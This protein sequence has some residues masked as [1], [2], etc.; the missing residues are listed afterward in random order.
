MTAPL[1]GTKIVE[2]GHMIAVPTATHLMAGY[3]ADVIKV[4]DLHGGD[5]VRVYA[6]QKNGMG[7][8]FI[9]ANSGKRSIALDLKTDAAKDVLWRLIDWADI[10]IEGFRP[11]VTARL[12]FGHEAVQKRRPDIIYCT[13][14]GFGSDGPYGGRPAFDP[15]IQALTGWAGMQQEGGEPRLVKG[16]VADKVSAYVN[17][18]AMMAAL[19]KKASTGEG[20]H[21]ETTML[22]A[23]IGFN[24]PDMMMDCTLLDDDVVRSDNVMKHYQ[25]YQCADGWISVAA[26]TDAQVKATCE[27]LERPELAKDERFA[28]LANR[29]LNI[30][31]WF[32]TLGMLVAPF[33]VEAVVDRL[34]N[35]RVPAAPVLMPREVHTDAHVAATGLLLETDHPTAGTLR[36]PRAPAAFFGEDLA[37]SPAPVLG[38]HTRQILEELGTEAGE[39]D[40]LIK[41]AAALQG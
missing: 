6:D 23:N 17:A 4:E 10:F 26:S 30:S 15:L 1:A 18:Q 16:I 14:S 36:Q 24:W 7:A 33:T 25:L 20:S 37:L 38:E 19:F 29:S 35:A 32:K 5:G 39:I 40:A 8:W 34:V 28:K 12:G 13:S 11:G 22:E 27:V 41:G 3:G 9:N 21:I 2:L 31:D